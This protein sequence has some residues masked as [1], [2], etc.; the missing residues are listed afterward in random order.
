MAEI[1][2]KKNSL[3]AIILVAVLVGSIVSVG[4]SAW[5]INSGLHQKGEKGETGATG[6]VGATGATGAIGAKG[7]MGLPGVPGAQGPK[8]NDGINGTN[9]RDAN[10]TV[11]SYSYLIG[12][13]ST[14]NTY[15]AQNGTDGSISFTS[16]NQTSVEI[17]VL[18]TSTSGSIVYKEVTFDTDLLS[19]IPKNVV[20]IQNLNSEIRK[21]GNPLNVVSQNWIISPDS[22]V[23]PSIW[24]ATEATQ[25]VTYYVSTGLV[26]CI[27]KV[28]DGM[29][30][31]GDIALAINGTQTWESTLNITNINV[32]LHSYFSWHGET[33]VKLANGMNSPMISITGNGAYIHNLGLDANKANNLATSYTVSVLSNES[34]LEHLQIA[35]S[36]GAGINLQGVNCIIS[37][38]IT[39]Y[40][41]SA[42]IQVINRGHNIIKDTGSYQDKW[43]LFLNQTNEVQ[44][45]NYHCF[46]SL[47]V[48]AVYINNSNRNTFTNCLLETNPQAAIK[49]M[50]SS[51]NEFK[52][53]ICRSNGQTTTNTYDAIVVG[54]TSTYN[55][56]DV[57]VQN[58]ASNVN[59]YGYFEASA[60]DDYNTISTSNFLGCGTA[61][62]ITAG[63][64]T[65]VSQSWN[66]TS[67]IGFWNGTTLVY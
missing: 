63:T 24:Y 34:M 14:N 3:I 27:Q 15:Y 62:I 45:T 12:V 25:G 21:F 54:G 64:H 13:N 19:S 67:L 61:G 49:L 35:F 51:F 31:G 37:D 36:A 39:D 26:S 55:K 1:L 18:G 5:L 7:D 20:V 32:N 6:A 46:E 42:G 58:L 56:F 17:S 66:G 41:N 43:G 33:N 23:S 50:A 11:G 52:G 30:D 29:V 65:T 2:I 28:Q 4:I 59:R 10:Y 40:G 9:G 53:T 38:C 22:Q 57:T 60:T 16:T 48:A 44:V 47:D 8:G